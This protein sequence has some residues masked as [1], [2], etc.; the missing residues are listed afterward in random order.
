MRVKTKTTIA[1]GAVLAGAL[2]GGLAAAFAGGSGDVG[3]V[4][5]EFR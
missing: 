5:I 3:Q 2:G 4:R 1:L